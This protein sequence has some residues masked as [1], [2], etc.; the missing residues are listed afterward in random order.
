MIGKFLKLI[1]GLALWGVLFLVI[2]FV[3][4]ML[5]EY[6]PKE[7]EEY[8]T[9]AQS[10]PITNDTIT[11]ISWNIGYA[12]LGSDMDFFLDGG[13]SSRTSRGRTLENLDGIISFIEKWQDSVDFVLLQEVDF[14]S[15]RTYGINEYDTIVK[16]FGK[17]FHYYKAKNFEVF[18]VPIPLGNAI[19][20]VS[21]G[22][23]TMSRYAPSAA[24]RLS[25]PSTGWWPYSMFDLKRC[26]LSVEVP[27][28]GRQEALYINNTHNSAY[29]SDGEGRA[30]EIGFMALFLSDKKYS[31]TAGDWNSVPPDYTMSQAEKEDKYFNP[32]SVSRSDFG[33]DFYFASD[34][35][36]PSARY[37]YEPYRRGITTTTVIDFA[38]SSP[39]VEPIMVEC[40]DLGFANSDHNPVVYKFVIK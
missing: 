31:V 35:K 2:F 24:R 7:I 14:G 25:Y 10:Q 27:I 26:M 19:G 32:A 28:E 22:V 39:K 1:G 18:Y 9:L 33:A 8:P 6:S 12:G 3:W 17:A 15:F 36:N 21:A 13:Q 5:K 4:A 11:I 23:V 38:V 29:D 37:G 20:Q 30:K 40:I 16:H 34:I